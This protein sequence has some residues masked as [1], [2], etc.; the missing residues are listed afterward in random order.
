MSSEKFLDMDGLEYFHSKLQKDTD[1]KIA[2]AI[3]NVIFADSSDS[4]DVENLPYLDAE[5]LNGYTSDDFVKI[6]NLKDTTVGN[7]SKLDGHDITHFVTQDTISSL[8]T[9]VNDKASQIDLD[10]HISDT[11]VHITSEERSKLNQTANDING[12]IDGTTVVGEATKSTFDAEGN[13]ISKTYAKSSDV[14]SSISDLQTQVETKVSTTRKINGKT[15]ENDVNITA[16]DVN[17]D[18]SGNQCG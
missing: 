10:D 18:V 15:L 7:A 13:E 11:N 17:A 1:K 14:E 16:A 8:E 12:I 9:A 3:E 2:E 6:K 4:E 5:K